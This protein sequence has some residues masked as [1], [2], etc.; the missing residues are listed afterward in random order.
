MRMRKQAKIEQDALKME[1]AG[2]DKAMIQRQVMH[3]DRW[4]YANIPWL[5]ESFNYNTS[6]ITGKA[7]YP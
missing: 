7:I 5:M 6:S 2:K 4:F 1:L 3:N